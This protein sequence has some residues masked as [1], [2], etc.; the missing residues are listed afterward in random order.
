MTNKTGEPTKAV[1]AMMTVMVITKGMV[2]NK[3]MVTTMD[4]VVD[5]TTKDTVDMDI[6]VVMAEAAAEGAVAL[7]EEDGVAPLS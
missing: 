2:T 7:E 4:G 6:A 1:E 5:T 3:A